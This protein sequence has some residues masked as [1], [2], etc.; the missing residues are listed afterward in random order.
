MEMQTKEWY[1]STKLD[2]SE[3]KDEL[4]KWKKLKVYLEI[5]DKGQKCDKYSEK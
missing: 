1:I 3:A 4:K 2:F 5:E